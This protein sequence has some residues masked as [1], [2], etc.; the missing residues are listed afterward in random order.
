M[1]HV[2]VL[3]IGAGIAGISTAIWCKRLGLSYAVIEQHD[4]LGGQISHIH[5]RIWDLPPR[6]YKD[7]EELLKE[8]LHTV[9]ELD[10]PIRFQEKLNQIDTTGK[11]VITDKQS[12]RADYV[13]L[14][15]GVRQVTLPVLDQVSSYVLGPYFSTT[16][17]AGLL[18]QKDVMV[19]GGGDRALESVCNLSPH[20]S[21]IWLLVRNGHFRAREEWVAKACLLPNVTIL[22]HTEV[23]N[24]IA[25]DDRC[26][27][28]FHTKSASQ[29]ISVDWIMPRI[30]VTSQTNDIINLPQGDMGFIQ[31]DEFQRTVN[32]WMYSIGDSANG[33][34]YSSLSLAI[35][36]AMK[37]AKHISLCIKE[38]KDVH[39]S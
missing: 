17:Q 24:A 14:A 39:L 34:L 20:A 36:Q 6:V 30:G 1:E 32:P 18:H 4:R 2:Q 7:G 29:Q 35:G 23:E 8:L 15:T 27:V 16:A 12:Y 19:I 13:V 22:M 21:H 9:Q 25:M 10:I 28:T 37:T 33:S 11:Q 38:A 3:I 5:S 31:V 26:L